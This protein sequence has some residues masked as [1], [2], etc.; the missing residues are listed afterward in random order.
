MS[1][2]ICIDHPDQLKGYHLGGVDAWK[3]GVVRLFLTVRNPEGWR[4]MTAFCRLDVLR[5]AREQGI[6]ARGNGYTLP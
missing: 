1:T 2:P 6:I 4:A 5:V 3:P